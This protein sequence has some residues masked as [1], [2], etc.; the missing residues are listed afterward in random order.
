M[1]GGSRNL[2][3]GTG[4]FSWVPGGTGRAA[5]GKTIGGRDEQRVGAS[6]V[7]GADVSLGTKAL[8]V[9]AFRGFEAA[10]SA[11]SRTSCEPIVLMHGFAGFR[12]IKVGRWTMLE[13]FE[14][15][16]RLLGAM[17]YRAFAPEVSP[18]DD[19]LARAGQWEEAIDKIRVL[20]GA[21]KVHLVGHSQGGL[22][23]RVLVAPAGPPVQTPIGWLAGRGYAPHVASVTTIATPHFGSYVA[24]AVEQD[25]PGHNVAVMTL[26]RT[27]EIIAALIKR[28]PQNV[29]DAVKALTREFMLEQFNPIIQDAEGVRYYAVAGDPIS[30]DAVIPALRLTYELLKRQPASVGG[31]PN[32]GLVT[33]ESSLFGKALPRDDGG[34]QPVA[35]HGRANWES[36]GVLQADH[37]AEV[38]LPLH[39]L[40]P[41]TYDHFAF[42]AGLAQ[43]LDEAYTAKMTLR[44][45]GQ[46]ER[47]PGGGAPPRRR[48]PRRP[49]P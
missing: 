12:E 13:Y 3:A 44:M 32:D 4:G 47:V 29:D 5:I 28:K 27:M 41:N 26:K 6:S 10:A 1:L 24:D 38:G 7:C 49:R 37:I 23:A 25:I 40:R 14:S 34:A 8:A 43:F 33:V 39:L 35:P 17:G 21:E 22:D 46:W 45:D 2:R 15:V 16:R 9:S 42:F 11:P 20:T 19:P 18:F 31:G 30:D 48:R 36:L